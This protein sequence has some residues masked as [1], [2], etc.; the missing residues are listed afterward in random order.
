VITSPSE[1]HTYAN[2]ITYLPNGAVERFIYGNGIEHRMAQNDRQ[3]P[4]SS[5]ASYGSTEFVWDELDYDGHGNVLAVADLRPGKAGRRSRTM[6]YDDLD[7][8]TQV[9]SPMFGASGA[10]YT[11]NVFDDPT[12]VK[13]GGAAARDHYYCYDAARR[14]ANVKTGGCGGA[15]VIGLGYDVQGNLQN[16]NGQQYRF[17]FGNR[18]REVDGVERYRYD[19]HGRRVL[20]MTFNEGNVLSQYA[21]DG[22][23]MFQQSARTGLQSDMV[24]L[25]GS[26]LAIREE[27]GSGGTPV[28]KYQH[29]DALGSPVVVTLQN[30]AIVEETEYEPYGKVLNRPVHDGPGYTGH[31][32]D[33]ATGLTYMQQRYYDPAI[34]KFLSVDPVTANPN[35]GASFNRYNYAN[36]NPYRFTDPDGRQACVGQI[37]KFQCMGGANPAGPNPRQQSPEDRYSLGLEVKGDARIKE[38]FKKVEEKAKAAGMTI[39]DDLRNASAMTYVVKGAT[40][41]FEGGSKDGKRAGIVRWN[42]SEGALIQ[43][44]H[45]SGSSNRRNQSPALGLIHELGHAEMYLIQGDMSNPALEYPV[46]FGV[47]TEWANAYGEPVRDPL[48]AHGGLPVL[49]KGLFD[50]D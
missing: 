9:A 34:G 50:H 5:R 24:Y 49:G 8:L 37:P 27:P 33:A 17:D 15:T 35:T 13:I 44:S 42:P 26:L 2:S 30:R 48:R 21:F 18:L 41:G 31:V 4:D 25:A 29:T 16:K 38:D 43:S 46:I 23:L 32:E 47:E 40:T 28:V 1:G 20:A 7:R 10:T 14:L 11:Y 19:G 3:L 12:R 39:F 22:K 6:D 45:L 36:N